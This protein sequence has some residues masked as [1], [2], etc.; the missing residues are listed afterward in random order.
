MTAATVFLASAVLW[1]S[2]ALQAPGTTPA[3]AGLSATALASPGSAPSSTIAIFPG[4]SATGLMP[5]L[6]RIDIRRMTVK[7]TQSAEITVPDGTGRI[8]V[9]AEVGQSSFRMGAY[10]SFV[11]GRIEAWTTYGIAVWHGG[12]QLQIGASDSVGLGR[13][14]FHDRYLERTRSVPFGI[15]DTTRF[16]SFLLNASRTN[17]Q[18]APLDEPS[19]GET[20]RIDSWGVEWTSSG[21]LPDLVEVLRQEQ[22]RKDHTTV[23]YRRAFRGLGGHYAFDRA[24]ADIKSWIPGVRRDDEILLRVFGGQAWNVSPSLPLRE[25]Y[26]LGGADAL[27]GYRFEEFRGSGIALAGTEYAFRLPWTFAL[28]AVR[29][30]V[31]R[32]DVLAFAEDGRIQ[33]RWHQGVTPFLWSAGAGIRFTG[34]MLGGP[35]SIFRLY[36]AQAGEW[37]KRDPV[38]YALADIG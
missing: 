35:R 16:G 15:G 22:A 19:A 8:S 20:S 2:T 31:T 5:S 7:G 18:L 13:L 30:E 9:G 33:D 28:D 27:K 38:F 11:T 6:S 1:S 25:T 17:W 26:A 29:L 34:R 36:V 24:D 21:V 12:P 3:P 14:Y 4:L 10:Y 37:R 23:R 32:W